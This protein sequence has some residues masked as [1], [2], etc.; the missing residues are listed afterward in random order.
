MKK[1]CTKVV[2]FLVV[3]QLTPACTHCDCNKEKTYALSLSDADTSEVE[4]IDLKKCQYSG[5]SC[6]VGK[7]E[8]KPMKGKGLP[9]DIP[10]ARNKENLKVLV[11]DIE[12]AE[13]PQWLA[14]IESLIY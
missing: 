14:L 9:S 3:F 12:F 8:G 10:Q 4:V 11:R 1:L 13:Q 6:I 5:A 7:S 2:L